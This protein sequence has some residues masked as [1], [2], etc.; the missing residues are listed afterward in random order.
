MPTS[1]VEHKSGHRG[2]ENTKVFIITGEKAGL[3]IDLAC[4]E[5]GTLLMVG[6][7]EYFCLG[8]AG[9][10][11]WDGDRKTP[12]ELA[13]KIHRSREPLNLVHVGS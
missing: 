4:Q 11:G 1:V 13:N 7:L 5:R 8:N 2:P 12:A 3:L 9:W 6:Q 10:I